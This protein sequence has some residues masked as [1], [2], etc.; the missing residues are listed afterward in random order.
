MF[1]LFRRRKPLPNPAFVLECAAGVM[2]ARHKCEG[3]SHDD[4]GRVDVIGAMRIAAFGK[5]QLTDQDLSKMDRK[6]DRWDIYTEA[7]GMLME[8][9]IANHPSYRDHVIDPT[10]SSS[11]LAAWSDRTP[12]HLVI[13]VLEKAAKGHPIHTLKPL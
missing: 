10:S 3:R 1:W 8:Y 9:I 13:E 4:W 7:R 11:H 5:A 12:E 6:P 2:R